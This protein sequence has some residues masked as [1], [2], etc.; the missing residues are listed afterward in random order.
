MAEGT[1][2]DNVPVDANAVIDRLGRRIAQLE[3]DGVVKDLVNEQLLSRIG[4]L[5]RS[6]QA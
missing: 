1:G 3:L 6:A 5:E 4:E 2:H